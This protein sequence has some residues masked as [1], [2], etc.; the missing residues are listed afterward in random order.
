MN[1]PETT[2]GLIAQAFCTYWSRSPD[3]SV[4]YGSHFHPVH[5]WNLICFGGRTRRDIDEI[6]V[7]RAFGALNFY[8]GLYV[9]FS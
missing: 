3:P 7:P 2:F 1:L 8:M 5:Q 6:V 9:L 4:S